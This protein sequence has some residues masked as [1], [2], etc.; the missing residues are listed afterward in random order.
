M[1]SRP[2]QIGRPLRV[3]DIVA[4][5][6]NMS[7]AGVSP[8]RVARF[9]PKKIVLEYRN[10]VTTSTYAKYCLVLNPYTEGAVLD[11]FKKFKAK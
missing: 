6:S 7:Y 9:T 4:Y 2:D 5:S 3:G 1:M 10:G 11:W 8:C